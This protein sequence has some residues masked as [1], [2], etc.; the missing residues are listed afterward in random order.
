MN[1]VA[2]GARQRARPNGAL[3][4]QTIYDCGGD[5]I[6]GELVERC[7]I[8]NQ[9]SLQ[10]RV[11]RLPSQPFDIHGLARSEVRER[12]KHNGRTSLI[13]AANGHLALETMDGLTADRTFFR[14]R[15]AS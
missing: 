15:D 6:H 5:L 7:V 8:R 11:D 13:D 4:S 10:Q 9:S 2:R 14:R 1:F 3:S 12:L